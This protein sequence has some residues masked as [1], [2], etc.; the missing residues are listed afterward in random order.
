MYD[1]GL[2]VHKFLKNL[3][4]TSE[5]LDARRVTC[6]KF[7]TKDLQILGTTIQ[8]LV[9]T[10]TRHP[11]FV[12]PCVILYLLSQVGSTWNEKHLHT[13][14]QW[15]RIHLKLLLKTWILVN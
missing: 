7:H 10:V 3:G 12:H 9:T 5:I 6:S 1:V 2:G 8:N 15:S 11:G 14:E 4:A 13:T